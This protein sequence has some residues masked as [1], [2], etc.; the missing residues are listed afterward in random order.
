Y[1]ARQR[2][3]DWNLNNSGAQEGGGFGNV[4]F[5]NP[6]LKWESTAQIYIGLDFGFF[7][8]RLRGTIDYYH[9]KTKDLLMQVTS[10]QP[11]AQPFVWRNLDASVV[12]SGV[13]LGLEADAVDQPGFSWTV[14]ANAAYN[15]NEVQ[16][17]NGIIN[18]G[19]I[20]G[21]GLSGAFAQR[22]A[23]G[24]PLFAW[25]VRDFAGYDE[26]GNAVYN[27]GDVQ[28]FVGRSPIPKWNAGLT[29]T[30]RMGQWDVSL[31]FAGQF[32]HYVYNNT[33]NA[34]FTAGALANG[35]NTTRDV[36]TS[37][38][39]RLNSPDVSTR[40]LEDGSFIRLQNVSLGYNF[41]LVD[42]FISSLRVFVTGQNLFV[43]T[44]YSG[45]DPEVNINK[46]LDGVP[47]LN[48]DYTS[49]P[50]ARTFTFGVNASF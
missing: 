29:N 46:S 7:A 12:N 24:Q 35:R 11:A 39:G 4:A 18:T 5:E 16:D 44:D 36:V 15:H 38:E 21:Q 30:F 49:Y 23:G 37:G 3:G 8:N 17:F 14:I 20:H 42:K 34:Y 32:G 19:A 25:F 13:E 43:I 9:K 6:E 27:G 41:N 33:A 10:A 31:F 47:S 48:I 45:Q 40:F 1:V 22:I 2:Y 28:K 26:A 50:R